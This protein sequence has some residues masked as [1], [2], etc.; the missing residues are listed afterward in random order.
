MGHRP[1]GA[2]ILRRMLDRP[3]IE[4]VGVYVYSRQKGGKEVGELVRR[5]H[6]GVRATDR[7]ED[8]VVMEAD[9]V[10]RAGRLG[11]YDNHDDEIARFL[12]SGKNVISINGYGY[13]AYWSNERSARLQAAC[14]TW[15]TPR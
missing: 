3:A 4:G 7:A 12:A 1:D 5:S 8:I 15:T 13:T 10:V 6:V 9:V 14:E 11:A 2:P